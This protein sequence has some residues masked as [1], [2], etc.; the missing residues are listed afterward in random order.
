MQ[1][2]CRR[3][4]AHI[5]G[6]RRAQGRR[7]ID[8][9]VNGSEGERT[10]TIT[11]ETHNT[12]AM[13]IISTTRSFRIVSSL[14]TTGARDRRSG[15]ISSIPAAFAAHQRKNA[16]RYDGF[17]PRNMLAA[18]PKI[19]EPPQIVITQKRRNRKKSPVP[20]VATFPP[21]MRPSVQAAATDSTQLTAA[22]ATPV[23]G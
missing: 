1:R 17:P 7:N 14:R 10:K 2:G 13:A 11:V 8:R 4:A 18:A 9:A 12:T 19:A 21:V 6:T 5:M 23:A 3:S 15:V 22:L 16:A 20:R